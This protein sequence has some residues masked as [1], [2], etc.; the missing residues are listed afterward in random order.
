MSVPMELSSIVI[1]DMLDEQVISLR[2]VDGEREFSIVIG[3]NEAK[4]ISRRLKGLIPPRPMT[5]ELLESVVE[6][7]GAKLEAIE[8]YNLQATTYF[9]YLHLR[10]GQDVRKV[11]CRP[12]DAIALGAAGG[13]QIL[14]AEHVLDEVAR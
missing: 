12:S 2:E 4:A 9:A 11:D 5:H 14:V 7:L 13:V 6:A 1:N 3:S 8:I 10:H